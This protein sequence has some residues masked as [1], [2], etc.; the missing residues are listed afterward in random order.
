VSSSTGYYPELYAL[1][2]VAWVSGASAASTYGD[3]TATVTA[4]TARG[5]TSAYIMDGGSLDRLTLTGG[6]ITV[7]PKTGAGTTTGVLTP[8]NKTLK[9]A[10]G[11]DYR[12]FYYG[13]NTTT[14][15]PLAI[16]VTANNAS[17]TYGDANPALTYKV[18]T[19]NLI[20]GDKLS[21]RL[22][23]SATVTSNVGDYDIT[24]GTLRNRNYE[25]TFVGG[26]LTVTPGSIA[27][28]AGD[29]PKPELT[30]A[31]AGNLVNN[32]TLSGALATMADGSSSVGLQTV[33]FGAS[34]PD[35]GNSGSGNSGSS[36]MTV[37]DSRLSGA[38][39]FITKTFAVS[40][41]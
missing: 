10:N 19:G 5:G 1:T 33:N 12:V 16:T 14:V 26:T 7:D 4:A 29:A 3:S 30:F 11:M 36:T 20:N 8:Q 22:A 23:T 25:I 13:S 24:Q 17:R 34:G 37:A 21:G 40:C 18:T 27:V 9:S 38:S 2:P 32:D 39:C 15:T 41:D 6:A 35:S 28:T 31:I